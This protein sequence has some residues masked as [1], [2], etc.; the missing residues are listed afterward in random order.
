MEILLLQLACPTSPAGIFEEGSG[1]FSVPYSACYRLL[2][3][4]CTA[5]AGGSPQGEYCVNQQNR[6][7]SLI[8]SPPTTYFSLHRSMRQLYFP[9]ISVG[10][11]KQLLSL[12]IY[13][14]IC[15]TLSIMWVDFVDSNLTTGEW[16]LG[17]PLTAK[18]Y[19]K[20]RI[21]SICFTICMFYLGQ[22]KINCSL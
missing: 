21:L 5:G 7:G 20:Q 8:A 13:N 12:H 4:K 18:I 11:F 10:E 1:A 16:Q 3:V 9:N 6:Q 14:Y 15:F 22:M 19:L 2:A 17:W